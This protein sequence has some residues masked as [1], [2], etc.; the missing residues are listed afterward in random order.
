MERIAQA[1]ELLVSQKKE[2]GEIF[3]GFETLNR[4]AITESGGRELFYAAEEKGSLLARLF[5]KSLRP[6]TIKLLDSN[7]APF[8]TLERPFKFFFHTINVFDAQGA[9]LGSVV[10]RFTVL[11]RKYDV[12]DRQG[13][14]VLSLF[15]PVLKPWTFFIRQGERELGKI[16]KKWSGL[17][18]ESFSAADNFGVEFRPDLTPDRKALLLG[19]VFLIDFV[20]FENR[21]N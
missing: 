9:Q 19:A 20:H 15:G 6:F 4:Y 2:W 12:L 14:V 10:R 7:S 11:R 13:N 21:N 16:F 3:T 5:L 18:K 8:M 1:G 17:L